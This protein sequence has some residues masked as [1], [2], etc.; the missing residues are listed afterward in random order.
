MPINPAA[1]FDKRN[2]ASDEDL[3]EAMQMTENYVANLP[4][5]SNNT[6]F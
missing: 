1:V 4:A 5:Q 3:R 6:D 2:I